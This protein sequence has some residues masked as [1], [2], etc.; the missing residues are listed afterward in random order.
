M[1]LLESA[2][3]TVEYCPTLCAVTSRTF[4]KYFRSS[5][6]YSVVPGINFAI[7]FKYLFGLRKNSKT[8]DKLASNNG[9]IVY[10]YQY[11]PTKK[12]PTNKPRLTLI[13]FPSCKSPPSKPA[14]ASKLI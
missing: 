12:V 11:I 4:F 13:F 7:F 5:Y 3:K 8:A 6:E 2:S 10:A 14:K 9:L 1:K